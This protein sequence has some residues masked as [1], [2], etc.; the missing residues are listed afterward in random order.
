MAHVN[1]TPAVGRLASLISGVSDDQLAGPTPCPAY[2]LGD[3]IDHVGGLALAFNAAGRKEFGTYTEGAPSGDAARLGADWRI[4]IPHDLGTLAQ[5]W[6]EPGAWEGMTR[7][8]QMDAPGEMV[9]VTLADELLVHGWDVAM[10]SG[11][12]FE[13]EPEVLEAAHSFLAQIANPDAPAGPEVA[14]GPPR[15]LPE[16]APALDRVVAM[17]GRDHAWSAR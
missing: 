15:E 8:A 7:I 10:A 1:L 17:A 2:T 9:G 14:F 16:S 6:Q 4:R 5:T 13:Y 12:A 3:L 11:Q